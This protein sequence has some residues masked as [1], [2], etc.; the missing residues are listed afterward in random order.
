MA[1]ETLVKCANAPCECLVE[2]EQKYCSSACSN[3]RGS[4]GEPC[5]CGHPGCTGEEV[6]RQNESVRAE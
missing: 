2:A 5:M 4:A 3:A 6:L 1:S